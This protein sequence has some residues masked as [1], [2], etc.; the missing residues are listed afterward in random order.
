MFET[1]LKEVLVNGVKTYQTYTKIENVKEDP[2]NP[3]DI[4]D[5][6][7]KDLKDFIS[8]YGELKPV[9]VDIRAEKEGQL[10]GGNQRLRAYKEL[11]KTELWINPIDPMTDAQAWEMAVLDNQSFGQY[12]ADK[13]GNQLNQYNQDIDLSKLGVELQTP[14]S[15]EQLLKQFNQEVMPP[16]PMKYE[17]IIKCIDESDLMDKMTQLSSLGIQAKKRGK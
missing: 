5:E 2:Q 12:L 15:F 3:R 14:L 7:L 11:G 8:K 16:K 13:L 10:I 17:I 9:L 4:S 1:Y 6:K